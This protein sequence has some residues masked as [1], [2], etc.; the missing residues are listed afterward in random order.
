M[1]KLLFLLLVLVNAYAGFTQ[2]NSYANRMQHIFGNIDKTK[3]TT[4]YLKEFGI[5]FNEIEAYNGVLNS[6]NFVD[7]TQW[8]SLYSSL[9]TMR[10]GSVATNMT[11][12]NTIFTNLKNQ[13]NNTENV[14]FIVQ[15]YNYQQYKAN[16]YTNGDVT[17]SNDR[18]YD[19]AGRNPYDTKTVFAVTSVVA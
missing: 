16:G 13:Q 14:L 12:P 3:V 9:Y 1:K 6:T 17:V 4:G 19:V 10:I 7:K 15:H 5:R 18:I 11:A 8:Q 2:N